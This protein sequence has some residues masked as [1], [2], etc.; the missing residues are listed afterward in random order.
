MTGKP[1]GESFLA[2]RGSKNGNPTE[3]LG[4]LLREKVPA[5]MD[6]IY[7]KLNG[8]SNSQMQN[9]AGTKS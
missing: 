7:R 4:F 9:A 5:F 3:R 2:K 6:L 1:E 8:G